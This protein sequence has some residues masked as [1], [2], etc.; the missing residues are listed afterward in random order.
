MINNSEVLQV[1]C[2]SNDLASRVHGAMPL[3]A[4]HIRCLFD[5]N[6]YHK[7]IGTGQQMDSI[8]RSK[9]YLSAGPGIGQQRPRVV[10]TQAT[11]GNATLEL[12]NSL[13]TDRKARRNPLAELRNTY[14]LFGPKGYQHYVQRL[15][16]IQFSTWKPSGP[17]TS[18][19]GHFGDRF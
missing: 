13:F 17:A 19:P 18:D 1:L 12:L 4:K 14:T 7:L 11:Q 9:S 5:A 15:A 10:T 16:Y 3:Y 2:Q 8:Q 6:N